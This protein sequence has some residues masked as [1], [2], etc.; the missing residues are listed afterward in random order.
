MN[1]EKM[2]ELLR[3]MRAV[4]PD[5]SDM[6][7]AGKVGF[8]YKFDYDP[9]VAY[10][11]LDVVKFGTSLWTPKADTIGNPPP[12]QVQEGQENIQENDYWVLFLPGALGGDYIKKTDL[13]VAPTETDSGKAGIVKPDG[14][15]IQVDAD[16]LLT[17]T[18]LDFMGTWKGLQDAIE[19]GE[20]K[21]GMVGYISGTGVDGEDENHPNN[22]L[23]D[24]DDFLSTISSNA[25]QNRIIAA[26]INELRGA[27]EEIKQFR[28]TIESFGFSKIS[29]STSVTELDSGLVLSA[30]EKNASLPGTIA[31]RI[32]TV[33]DSS[34]QE[35]KNMY[36]LSGGEAIPR[37]ADLDAYVQPGNY[38][39]R[40]DVIASSLLNCPI[41]KAF[42]MKVELC[43]GTAY[44][45][46][47]LRLFATG[48][49]YY[50]INTESGWSKYALISSAYI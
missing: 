14:K 41:D 1:E 44:P 21:N 2:D 15:T 49:L 48:S 17:G 29:E 8:V 31:N 30:K 19:S 25:V 36:A 5:T 6:S 35:M 37:G 12:D 40:Y 7:D 22:M 11:K 47:T 20:A 38:Y 27:L 16:G 24:F 50:R 33:A 45:C 46:Q 26:V 23:F 18:P 3:L 9:E 28:A 43:I 42:T 10:E 32:E 4:V 34:V 13:A 39:C